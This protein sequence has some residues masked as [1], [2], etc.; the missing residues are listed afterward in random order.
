MQLF[1]HSISPKLASEFDKE[2]T[3]SASVEHTYS[4]PKSFKEYL[5]YENIG[6]EKKRSFRPEK[7]RPDNE[8]LSE[9]PKIYASGLR[10]EN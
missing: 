6:P 4:R 5:N 9:A 7:L 1:K 2:N 10:P 8:M 3:E